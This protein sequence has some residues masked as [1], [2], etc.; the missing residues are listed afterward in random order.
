MWQPQVIANYAQ[1]YGIK[2][3]QSGPFIKLK[4]TIAQFH[5]F[6]RTNFMLYKYGGRILYAPEADV[7]LPA[8][9][10]PYVGAILGL[11]N[12]TIATPYVKYLSKAIKKRHLRQ[13]RASPTAG[14]IASMVLAPRAAL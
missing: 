12:I 9:I 2:V 14:K 5:Q 11:H 7:K 4:G 8:T 10:A 6:F 1:M 3:E 13:N